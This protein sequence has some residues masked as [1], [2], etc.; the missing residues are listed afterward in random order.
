MNTRSSGKRMTRS[1]KTN[2]TRFIQLPS[3]NKHKNKKV[4]KTPGK[5]RYSKQFASAETTTYLNTIIPIQS[6]I[7][8][9]DG[10]SI[11][12]SE[13]SYIPEGVG[14]E[15]EA[16]EIDENDEEEDNDIK[17]IDF[18]DAHD[19]WIA[20]KKRLANGN[21]VYLCGKVLNETRKCRRGCYDKIGLYSGCKS[22]FM[23][24]ENQHHN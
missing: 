7:N 23:W 6:D 19:E 8:T 9:D 15:E 12:S 13:D 2:N 17:N 11:A 24:E 4:Y 18:D 5:P 1:I 3:Y 16:D 21:Y 20:N 10:Y 22:H 14:Q